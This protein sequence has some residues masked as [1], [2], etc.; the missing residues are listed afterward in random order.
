MTDK[1]NFIDCISKVPH[2][3]SVHR[4]Y[5]HGEHY[6]S[7]FDHNYYLITWKYDAKNKI[8]IRMDGPDFYDQKHGHSL[9]KFELTSLFFTTYTWYGLRST[10]RNVLIKS[11][12]NETHL[13][14]RNRGK[15]IVYKGSITLD[16]LSDYL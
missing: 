3:V 11:L 6:Q 9:D 4:F 5:K 2:N 14:L 7:D 12:S 1:L 13:A 15:E 8:T 10:Q 16:S